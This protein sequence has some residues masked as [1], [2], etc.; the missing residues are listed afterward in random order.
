MRSGA[1]ITH[2]DLHGSYRMDSGV[3]PTDFAV[4]YGAPVLEWLC[5]IEPATEASFAGAE[6]ARLT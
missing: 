1:Y 4:R 6:L 2:F 3:H 5:K